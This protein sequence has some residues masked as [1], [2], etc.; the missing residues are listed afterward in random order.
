MTTIA[1]LYK[2]SDK[3]LRLVTLID[4]AGAKLCN[5]VLH[6]K[7]GLPSDCKELYQWLK[8]YQNDMDNYQKK[9]LCPSNRET[10]ESK[11]DI[12]PYGKLIKAIFNDKY[13]AVAGD[14]R[15][16]RNDLHH[17]I[18]KDLSKLDFEKNLKSICEML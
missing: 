6:T 8:K 10:D 7:E 1:E 16:A 18:V 12:W 9:V 2:T 15:I 4:F 14:L 17:T 3:W 13:G 5:H 11:F